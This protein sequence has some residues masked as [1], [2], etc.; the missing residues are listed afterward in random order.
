MQARLEA[1]LESSQSESKQREV[2]A[3]DTTRNELAR[4]WAKES[5]ASARSEELSREVGPANPPPPPP[6]P[7]L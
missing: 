3:A 2:S 5:E 7:A 1:E 6:P 4:A